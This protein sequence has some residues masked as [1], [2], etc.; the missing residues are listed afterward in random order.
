MR[1]GRSILS[2]GNACADYLLWGEVTRRFLETKDVRRRGGEQGAGS[3]GDFLLLVIVLLR[4]IHILC[5]PP[6]ERV[7]FSGF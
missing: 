3:R 1:G 2:R 7:G 5:R 6:I 4:L